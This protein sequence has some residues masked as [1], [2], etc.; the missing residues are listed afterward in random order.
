ML[1]SLPLACCPYR[2]DATP[3]DRAATRFG[4]FI[5]NLNL[6][7]ASTFRTTRDVVVSF[8]S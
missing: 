4:H 7:S 2:M 5:F 3:F 8:S 1:L 6:N